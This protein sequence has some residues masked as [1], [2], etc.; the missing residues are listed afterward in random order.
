MGALDWRASWEHE[1]D[2]TL[3]NSFELWKPMLTHLWVTGVLICY[4][5]VFP[6]TVY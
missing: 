2:M 3:T 1:D 4:I 6:F 5:N